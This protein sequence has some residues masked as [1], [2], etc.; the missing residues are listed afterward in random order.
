[1]YDM[2][3][4]VILELSPSP[5]PFKTQCKESFYV[6]NIGRMLKH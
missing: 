4:Q 5:L 6:P 2:M 1:M 3:N